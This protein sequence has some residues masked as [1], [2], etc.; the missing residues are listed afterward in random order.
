MEAP[1]AALGFSAATIRPMSFVPLDRAKVHA[2]QCTRILA[3]RAQAHLT[4]DPA[5]AN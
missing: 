5:A 2:L 4:I 1:F 3:T